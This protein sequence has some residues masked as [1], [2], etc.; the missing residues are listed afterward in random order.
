MEVVEDE[1]TLGFS[2]SVI[3][4]SFLWVFLDD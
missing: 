3:Q 1:A 4:S 2:S